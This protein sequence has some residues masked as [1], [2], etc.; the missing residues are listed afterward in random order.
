MIDCAIIDRNNLKLLLVANVTFHS[1][2]NV[3]LFEKSVPRTI[4][5]QND[6]PRGSYLRNTRRQR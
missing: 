3:Y 4:I 5:L 6:A 2:L 1:H